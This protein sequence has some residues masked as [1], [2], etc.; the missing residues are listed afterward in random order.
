M[1]LR[2][3]L[4]AFLAKILNADS[5]VVLLFGPTKQEIESNASINPLGIKLYIAENLLN[6]DVISH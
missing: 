4:H 5:F 1:F 3:G 2:N 6:F